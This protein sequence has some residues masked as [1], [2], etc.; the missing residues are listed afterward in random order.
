M[1]ATTPEL[2]SCIINVDVS[3]ANDVELGKTV[4]TVFCTSDVCGTVVFSFRKS[5]DVDL[6]VSAVESMKT[7]KVD[8]VA[9]KASLL[10]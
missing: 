5:S 4:D 1:L 7:S 3:I 8:A 2:V 6:T 10:E 9:S